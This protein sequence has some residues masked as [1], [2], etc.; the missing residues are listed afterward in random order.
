MNNFHSHSG[1]HY[2]DRW[3]VPLL[4]TAITEQR[5]IVLTDARQVDKSTLLQYAGP[6]RNW[7]YHTLDD[8]DVLR[9]AQEDPQAL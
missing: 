6:I 5:A 4:Q 7:R 1:W 3:I 2:L 9:P 8:L